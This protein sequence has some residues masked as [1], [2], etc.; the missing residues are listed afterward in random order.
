ML[1]NPEEYTSFDSSNLLLFLLYWR[2]LLIA[3][4]LIAIIVS[5]IVSSPF[6][7]TPKFRSTVILYPA[8]TSSI[9]KALLA[10]NFGGKDDILAFG[11]EEQTEQLLQIL[12]SNKIRD[13]I[14]EKY[15]LAKHYDI[16]EDSKF[17]M[18]E[19]V[20][21]YESNISFRR[22]EYMA[23]KIEVMDK[24]PQLAANIANDI[25]ILLDS[26]KSDMQKQ[27]ALKA[28]RIVKNEYFSQ[29]DE[30]R[31]ME[32]SLTILRQ[33][34]VH[35]YESQAEMI[36]RQ[37]AMELAKG[38]KPG[39]EALEKRLDILAKYGGPYVSIRD[40]L[41]HDKKQLSHIKSKYEE[42]KV[43]AEQVLPQTF[44][45]NNAYKAEKK[46]Y[47]IRWLIVAISTFSALL[48]ALILIILYENINRMDGLKK[49]T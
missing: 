17:R 42:A 34:G 25:A 22:T 46:A 13:R 33:F 20:R 19:L 36:N 38:N 28:Y 29:R 8:S 48:M 26:I 11:E 7:I 10:E 5:V 21:E 49:K 15:Q 35:D 31:A 9:S 2:K 6:F 4:A 30:I 45:V 43:D 24:D 47:P 1:K 40:A 3:V 27:R 37:L 44:I 14:I 16:P 23:V 12:N 18:T 39:I 32:D 41:E